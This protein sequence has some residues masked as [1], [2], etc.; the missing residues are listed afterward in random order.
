MTNGEKL[1]IDFPNIKCKETAF[2]IELSVNKNKI[3][4]ISVNWWNAPY[5]AESEAANC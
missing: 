4:N 3:G 1:C 2:E 5:K